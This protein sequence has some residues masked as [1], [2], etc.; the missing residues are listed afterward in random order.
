M[1]VQISGH[2]F[3]A[4]EDFGGVAFGL[5]F[6]PDFLEFAVGAN[7]ETTADDSLEGTAHEFLHA[8]RTIG[9]NHLVRRI[10]KQREIE[11][12][13]EFEVL[14]RLDGIGAGAENP[15]P[16]LVELGLG[17]AKLG[18]LDCSTGRAG[19]RKEK[20]NNV[21]AFEILQRDFFSIVGI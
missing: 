11:L 12:L 14:Q 20:Q 3:Q 1:K 8:P 4:G 17:V 18:R 10:A 7:Q 19:F 6:V 13:L 9:L 15:N 5:Y 21:L 2:L 16:E